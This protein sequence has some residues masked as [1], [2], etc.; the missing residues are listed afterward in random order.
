LGNLT[1]QVSPDTGTTTKTFDAAGNALTQT[2]AK[3][4]VTTYAYDPLNRVSSATFHDGSKHVYAYD[5]G[6]NALGRLTGITELNPAQAVI[7]S[8]AYTYDPKGRMI[9]D[10]RTINGV[11]YTTGYRYDSSGRLDRITYPSGRTVDYTFDSLGRLSAVSTTPAGG[12]ASNVAT[13]ITYHPFGGVR[14]YT[15]GNGQSYTRSYDQ[16]GRI[17]SYTLG[18]AGYSIGYDAA[19]RIEFIT[20]I[21]NPTN[22]NNY[23]YDVLDRLTS[24]NTPGT[25]Y[26]YS[27]DPV[28]NRLSTTVGAGTGIYAYSTVSNRI[29]TITPSSG[30]VRSFAFDPNGSTTADGIN[31]YA[32]DVRG[33]MIQSVGSLDTTSYQVNALGQRVRKTGAASDVAFH[34]DSKGRLVAESMATGTML[35]EYVWLGDMPLA[36][37]NGAGVHF[38]HVD[39]LNTP[40]LMADVTGMTVWRWDQQEPFGNNV[41]DENPSGLGSFDLPLRLPGQYFDKETGQQYNY[42]RD[43]YDPGTG[44]YCQS[45]P[46]GLQGGLNTYLYALASPLLNVDPYGLQIAPPGGGGGVAIGG[47]SAAAGGAIGGSAAAGGAVGSNA[48]IAKGITNLLNSPA[49]SS[50]EE[51]PSNVIPFPPV[52]TSTPS[53]ANDSGQCTD[54]RC[55]FDKIRLEAEKSTLLNF[56][57]NQREVFFVMRTNLNSKIRAHNMRCAWRGHGVALYVGVSGFIP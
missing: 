37:V 15:L 46:I 47:A 30:P 9:S 45:D 36:V 19:S 8:T 28:G 49:S 4:Q 39:H 43:C 53:A 51:P 3:G 57:L 7:G 26:G 32:Y 40:R 29:A 44:R 13:D 42:F 48:S 5:A 22:S 33:R 17:N 38:I 14:S 56:E 1:S 2:D 23:G 25:N 31:T 52:P 6:T 50:G 24:A 41:A 54:D 12:T 55:Q 35:K 34:Y 16:D 18:A 27:Y 20:E 21:A 11:A 10:T